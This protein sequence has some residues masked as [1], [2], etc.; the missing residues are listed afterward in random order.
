MPA[1]AEVQDRLVAEMLLVAEVVEVVA[2]EHHQ[3]HPSFHF[4]RLLL[5]LSLASFVVIQL[6]GKL[7]SVAPA[8]KTLAA[9]GQ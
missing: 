4:H 6:D 3:A 5:D 8:E 1:A 9:L 7:H 2:E